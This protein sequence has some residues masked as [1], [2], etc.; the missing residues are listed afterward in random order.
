MAISFTEQTGT[1]NPFN[2]INVGLII[3]R[4]NQRRAGLFSA[5]TFADIDGDRHLRILTATAI[6]T[7]SSGNH[8]FGNLNYYENTGTASAPTYT[9]RTGTANPF[10]GINVGFFS[11]P[12]FADIDGDGDQDLVVGEQNGNLNYYENT[13]T[14]SAPTYTA[15]TGTANPFN[16][17]NVGFAST[18][19]FAD[20]DGDGD[21]DLVVGEFSR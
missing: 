19:T 4:S 9:E 15:R 11:T 1:A 2:G 3:Y 13:G 10:N 5:P 21:Q 18:P 20:I 12:T 14:A 6:R 17:I 16:G 8:N 7:S